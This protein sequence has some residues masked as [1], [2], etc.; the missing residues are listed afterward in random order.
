[1]SPAAIFCQEHLHLNF[2]PVIDKLRAGQYVW[3]DG[4]VADVAHLCSAAVEGFDLESMPDLR[5]GKVQGMAQ[6][7]AQ[8]INAEL[9]KMEVC[10]WLCVVVGCCV[11]WC[12]LLCA[13]DIC[14]ASA[15]LNTN[16]Q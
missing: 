14:S 13:A 15:T 7:L 12:V 6:Q 4:V 2:A 8:L 3:F 5:K 9:D 16:T 11:S 1:M 10:N